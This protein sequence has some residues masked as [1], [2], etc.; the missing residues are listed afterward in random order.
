MNGAEAGGPAGLVMG[1][2][3]PANAIAATDITDDSSFP[4]AGSGH[5]FV[6]PENP[7]RVINPQHVLLEHLMQD[8]HR[9][10]FLPTRS[11][12]GEKKNK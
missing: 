8:C 12:F 7:T 9:T 4:N 10:S 3:N 5:H 2:S 6:M 1:F 11:I